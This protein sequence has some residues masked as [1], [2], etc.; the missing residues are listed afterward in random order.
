LEPFSARCRGNPD[1]SGLE[2]TRIHGGNARVTP[3]V[4]VQ[5]RLYQNVHWISL[6][7]LRLMGLPR[8]GCYF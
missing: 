4:A 6:R 7:G 5:Q 2:Q 8:I 3:I 1:A